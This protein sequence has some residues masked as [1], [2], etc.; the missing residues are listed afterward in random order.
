[1]VALLLRLWG[2]YAVEPDLSLADPD[3]V[4]VNDAGWAGNVGVGQRGKQN[5]R[6]E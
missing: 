6:K 2:V 5:K 3:G 4:T 1:M